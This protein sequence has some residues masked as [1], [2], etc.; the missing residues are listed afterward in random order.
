LERIAKTLLELRCDAAALQEVG[1]PHRH[2]SP[3]ETADHA[4]FLGRRLGWYVAYGPNLVLAGR[5]YGNAI[6]SRFPIA[7][8]HNY[9]LSVEGREPRGCLRADL[10]L[11]EGR[12]L[13][14]F[15]LHL[16]LSFGERWKQAAMLLSADLLRDAALTAPLVVCGDFNLWSPL[17]GPIV[18]LL[19]A[20]LRDA[21]FELHKRK[22]T[23]PSRFP[24]IRLDRAYVDSGISLFGCG[25]LN[26]PRIREASDHLPL[27]VDLEPKGEAQG[28]A[29]GKAG[30]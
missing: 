7:G 30:A 23:W 3:H 29:V 21:A 6:L 8:A 17:P 5:P 12:T 2:G 16:G 13:H 28:L 18:R 20:A 25:V 27:W 1:D 15:D 9:D 19:R 24:V 10:S 26:D 4:A 14:L 22:A 11:P